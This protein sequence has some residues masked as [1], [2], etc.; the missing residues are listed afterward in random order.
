MFDACKSHVA[1][2]CTCTQAVSGVIRVAVCHRP[3]KVQNG[4]K[5]EVSFPNVSFLFFYSYIPS[6]LVLEGESLIT[7]WPSPSFW[8]PVLLYLFIYSWTRN[9]ATK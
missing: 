1:M 5:E 9:L 2:S 8:R 3:T 7:I 4:A 6:F